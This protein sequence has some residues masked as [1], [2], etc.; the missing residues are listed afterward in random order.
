MNIDIQAVHFDLKDETRDYIE[1]QIAK[2]EFASDLIV[3]L[4]FKLVRESNRFEEEVKIH[5][6]FGKSHVIKT[7]SFDLHE[8]LHE[9]ID[10]LALKVKKEKGKIKEHK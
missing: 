8:G 6:R 10:K 7:K 1:E 5:F 2:I 3:D 9:L 4:D